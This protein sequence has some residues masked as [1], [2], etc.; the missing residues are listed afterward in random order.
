MHPKVEEELIKRLKENYGK[1]SMEELQTKLGV[2]KSVF[3]YL[4]G[5]AGLPLRQRRIQ[6]ITVVHWRPAGA[7]RNAPMLRVSRHV[8]RKLGLKDGDKVQWMIE[9]GRIVGVPL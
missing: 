4:L 6:T 1:M 2:S 3:L 7:G 5:K 8:V 9:K